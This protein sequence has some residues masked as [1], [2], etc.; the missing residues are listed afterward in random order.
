MQ[1]ENNRKRS[2]FVS[3]HKLRSPY[4]YISIL[5]HIFA[6]KIFSMDWVSKTSFTCCK[7]DNCSNF[8][9]S[10]DL[11]EAIHTSKKT[12]VHGAYLVMDKNEFQSFPNKSFHNKAIA[13]FFCI[14]RISSHSTGE[15][16][17]SWDTVNYLSKDLSQWCSFH[18]HESWNWTQDHILK[19]TW[20]P[21]TWTNTLYVKQ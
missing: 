20:A 11:I 6:P 12:Y 8:Y 14:L 16:L 10:L 17:I 18:I 2:D 4:I 19:G 9:A 7:V 1:H 13:I 21:F 15:R 3:S 5:A